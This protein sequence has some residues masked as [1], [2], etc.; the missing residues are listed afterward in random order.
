MKMRNMEIWNWSRHRD[1]H[2]KM[3]IYSWNGLRRLLNQDEDFKNL[4]YFF[5]K[6]TNNIERQNDK[7]FS[8]TFTNKI[9]YNSR[10]AKN[11][12]YCLD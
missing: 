3:Y 5:N 1:D 6:G 12:E 10:A 7:D 2:E 11:R 8:K 9:F 4:T